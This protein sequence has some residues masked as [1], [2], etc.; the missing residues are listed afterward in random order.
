[1]PLIGRRGVK[2]SLGNPL[3]GA[4]PS[5]VQHYEQALHQFQCYCGD[6]LATIEAACAER[7]DFVMARVM[8]AW[9]HLLGSE[10]SGW[11]VARAD[12][13][14]VLARGLAAERVDA[15]PGSPAARELL[16]RAAG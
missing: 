15:K 5:S 2:D 13:E 14:Q 7:P 16:R 9:L 8:H 1:M 3:S 11:P 4:V 10:P 12:L 6:P